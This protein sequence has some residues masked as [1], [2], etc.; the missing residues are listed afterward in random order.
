M[1]CNNNSLFPGPQLYLLFMTIFTRGN[2][3]S[4]P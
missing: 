3:L 4:N 2:M 1:H